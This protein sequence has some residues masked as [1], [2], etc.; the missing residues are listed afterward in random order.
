VEQFLSSL[1]QVYIIGY[2]ACVFSWIFG[3]ESRELIRSGMVK[4]STI[5]TKSI[6]WFWILYITLKDLDE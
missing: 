4:P 2:L 1:F 5:L 6:W 3:A